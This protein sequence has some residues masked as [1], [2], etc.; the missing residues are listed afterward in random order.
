MTKNNLMSL[1]NEEVEML[2]KHKKVNVLTMDDRII[3]FYVKGLLLASNYPH[4]FVGFVADDGSCYRLDSI[5]EIE[6]KE[7]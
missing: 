1:S 2:F 5:K 3:T 7:I 4:L 6:L